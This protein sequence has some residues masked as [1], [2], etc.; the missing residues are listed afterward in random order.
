MTEVCSRQNMAGKMKL[1][2]VA[3]LT[4]AASGPPVNFIHFEDFI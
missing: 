2:N 1:L 4:S 3:N